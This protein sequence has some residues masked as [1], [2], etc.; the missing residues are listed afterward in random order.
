ML[1]ANAGLLAEAQVA[2]VIDHFGLYG[3]TTP[4]DADGRRLLDLVAL[5]HVWVKLSAPY[6]MAHGSL[7]TKPDRAW[8]AALV[9]AAPGRCVWGSDWPHPPAAD[10]H[11]GASIEAPYR[12]LSYATLVDDFLAALPS[13]DLADPIMATNAA[14]LYGF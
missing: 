4:A 14:A 8:L 13:A 6:R 5:S 3:G 12:P 7:N 1:L 2:V 10:K 11:K 9:A